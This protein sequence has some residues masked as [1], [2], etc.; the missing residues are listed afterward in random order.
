[1]SNLD[2]PELRQVEGSQNEASH[3]PSLVSKGVAGECAERTSQF[4][5]LIPGLHKELVVEC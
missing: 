1:M 3:A 5:A 2:W 4:W